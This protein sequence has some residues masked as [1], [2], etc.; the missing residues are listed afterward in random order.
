MLNFLAGLNAGLLGAMVLMTFA[1]LPVPTVNIAL[2]GVV[3][4]LLI[5]VARMAE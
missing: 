3:S 5:I 1:G 4:I 2:A